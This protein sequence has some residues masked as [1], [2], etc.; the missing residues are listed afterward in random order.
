LRSGFSSPCRAVP[1]GLP[2]WTKAQSWPSDGARPATL[3]L[4]IRRAA[5]TTFRPSPRIAKAPGFSAKKVAKFLIYPHPK[6]PDM[7]LTRHEAADLGA[8]IATL[9]R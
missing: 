5:P 8:Y 1:L 4:P 9:A 3:S 6:M 7:Q 2:M